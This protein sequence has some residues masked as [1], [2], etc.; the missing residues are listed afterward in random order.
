MCRPGRKGRADLTSSPPSSRLAPAV[1]PESS[2]LSVSNWRQGLRSLWHLSRH[3]TARADDN[4]AAPSQ[5]PRRASASLHRS[6]AIQARV[7]FLAYHRIKPHVP[8]LVRAPVNSFEFH[9]CRRTPQVEYLSLS[10]RRACISAHTPSI[11]RLLRGLP[12]YLILFDPHA[13]V[14]QRQMRAG[15]LPS[16]SEF[17]AI[18]MHFTATPR[19]P[20]ASPP[21]KQASFNGSPGLSPGISPLT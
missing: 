18:S 7:R 11:H 1:P 17:C 21:L 4:H 8:P 2:A 16:Q 19:I 3:L 10:L 12:G 20:H 15:T 9:R 6:A 13:F 5:R 14:P